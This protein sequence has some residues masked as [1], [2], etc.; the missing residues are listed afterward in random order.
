M[1]VKNDPASLCGSTGKS[2]QELHSFLPSSAEGPIRSQLPCLFKPTQFCNSGGR[3][4]PT[5]AINHDE[6]KSGC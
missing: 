6:T 1:K 3:T 5:T 2:V 4:E